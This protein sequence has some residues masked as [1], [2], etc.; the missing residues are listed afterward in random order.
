MALLGSS[1]AEQVRSAVDWNK[2]AEFEGAT[3]EK[4]LTGYIAQTDGVAIEGSGVTIGLGVDLGQHNKHD[5]IGLPEDLIKKLTPF[6]ELKGQAAL[7]S[8]FENLKISENEVNVL[9][10]HLKAKKTEQVRKAY[11]NDTGQEFYNL[12]PDAQTAIMSVYWQH[13]TSNPQTAAPKFWGHVTQGN[14][15]GATQELRNWS[16]KPDYGHQYRRNAEANIL[17]NLI[18]PQTPQGL[19]G[20]ISP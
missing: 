10:Q 15:G 13:G 19:L 5:L 18:A 4:R 1:K 20:L 11:N 9:D 6:L 12:P 7:N 8:S 16:D 2:I 17:A 3:P 14:W